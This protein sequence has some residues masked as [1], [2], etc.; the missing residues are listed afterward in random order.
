MRRRHDA[1]LDAAGAFTKFAD[2]LA[3]MDDGRRVT[4]TVTAG[5]LRAIKQ[6]VG[7]K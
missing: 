2:S 3:G 7:T 1:M 5:Q 6:A 4:I